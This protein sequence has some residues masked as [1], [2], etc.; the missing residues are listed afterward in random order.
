MQLVTSES[1]QGIN[2]LSLTWDYWYVHHVVMAVFK[3]KL[4]KIILKEKK[5][6]YNVF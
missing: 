4:V 1:G 3:C 5:S 6:Q 2:K